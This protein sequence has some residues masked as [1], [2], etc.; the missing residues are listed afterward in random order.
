[1]VTEMIRSVI[2]FLVVVTAMRIMGKRQV[3]QLLP[4]ELVI[5]LMIADIASSPM[6]NIGI[7]IMQG[8]VPVLTLVVMHSVFSI[9]GL[10]SQRLR[11]FI[12]GRP[13]ILVRRGVVQEKELRDLCFSLSDLLEEFRA[14]GVLNPAQVSTAILET[15]GKISVFPNGQNRP[16]TPK[17][18]NLQVSYEGIPLPLIM[19]GIVQGENLTQAGLDANWLS[20]HLREMGFHSPRQIFLASL[21]TDGM[22]FLQSCGSK[23]RLVMQQVLAADKV[24]W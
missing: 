11:G 17:D 19:D 10:K 3:G 9:I 4:Y 12:C 2:L 24:G 6:E 23:P 13:S 8:I 15:S 16:V 14:M 18:L 7:S 1:M 20:G 5:S 21:D 22:L